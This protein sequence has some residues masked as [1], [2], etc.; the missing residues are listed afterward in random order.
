ME[1]KKAMSKP[2]KISSESD[3]LLVEEPTYY[4]YAQKR[5]PIFELTAFQKMKIIKDGISKLYLEGFKKIAALDYNILAAALSVTRA[6]LINKKGASKFN[7]TL[8]ERILGLADIYAFGYD[9]FEDKN[10]FNKWMLTSNQALG[11]YAPIEM[12]TNQYGREE[13]RNIIGRIAYG[14][15]S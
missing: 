13:V 7:E 15:I 14:V 6:T 11:G 8:S 12:V 4:Y 2:Y 9:I 1:R 10:N 3:H 5:L